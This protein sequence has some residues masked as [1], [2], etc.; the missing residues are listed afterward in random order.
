MVYTPVAA[1]VKGG[2]I[3]WRS[4]S[5]IRSNR[6][7]TMDLGKPQQFFVIQSRGEN[8]PKKVDLLTRSSP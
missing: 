3:R 8:E 4:S 2:Q 5:P 1:M 6:R 7:Y